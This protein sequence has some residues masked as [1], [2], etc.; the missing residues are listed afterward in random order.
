MYPYRTK[1]VI[2]VNHS[3]RAYWKTNRPTVCIQMCQA[4]WS[5]QSFILRLCP[6]TKWKTR[7]CV[8]MCVCMCVCVHA[9]DPSFTWLMCGEQRKKGKKE[10]GWKS[11]DYVSLFTHF[12]RDIDITLCFQLIVIRMECSVQ[13][14]RACTRVCSCMRNH[15]IYIL[16]ITNITGIYQIYIHSVQIRMYLCISMCAI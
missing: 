9:V 16:F 11:A 3:L 8:N 2:R 10:R 1:C 6:K 5:V 7:W 13:Q 12:T 14:A 4:E 15:I